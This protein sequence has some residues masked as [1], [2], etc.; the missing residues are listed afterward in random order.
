MSGALRIPLALLLAALC[1]AGLVACG[2]NDDRFGTFTDCAS[3]GTPATAS[4][5]RG[6]QDGGLG[7]ADATPQGDLV[8]LR[9]A[10]GDGRLCAEF[11]AAGNIRPDAAYALVLRPTDAEAPVVQIQASV[12]GGANP[13]VRLSPATGRAFTKIDAQVGIDGDRLSIVVTRAELTRL[14]LTAIFDAFRFQ[15]RAA[16]VTKDDDRLADCLPSCR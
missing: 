16:V 11:R 7:A 5:P 10:R 4:D 8:G 3:I 1:V 14:G 9:I 6:D 2:G 15:G 13:E 12:L